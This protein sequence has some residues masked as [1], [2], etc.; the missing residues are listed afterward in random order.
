MQR[1]GVALAAAGEQLGDLW[2]EVRDEVRGAVEAQAFAAAA[3]GVDAGEADDADGP[4]AAP[5]GDGAAAGRRR[6]P[7]ARKP[8]RRTRSGA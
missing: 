2:A 5:A 4:V 8:R 7:A 3:A 1:T 6:R